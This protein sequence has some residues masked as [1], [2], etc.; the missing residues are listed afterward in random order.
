M[1]L[2]SSVDVKLVKPTSPLNKEIKESGKRF[3]AR[4]KTMP[5][6][7]VTSP[8][9]R[10]AA[11]E[12]NIK[13]DVESVAKAAPKQQ[14]HSPLKKEIK[15]SGKRFFA[16]KAT[17]PLQDIT[18]PSS[19]LAALKSNIKGD[20]E[21][22][23]PK[24]APQQAPTQKPVFVRD[25]FPQPKPMSPR[26][27][28]Q[29]IAVDCGEHPATLPKYDDDND[30]MTYTNT[31]R[32]HSRRGILISCPE[33]VEIQKML[34]ASVIEIE[35]DDSSLSICVN[36]SR[37]KR[38]L[39]RSVSRRRGS[40]ASLRT[41]SNSRRN[42]ASEVAFFEDEFAQALGL[43]NSSNN[44]S[45]EEKSTAYTGYQSPLREI[46][47]NQPTRKSLTSLSLPVQSAQERVSSVSPFGASRNFSIVVE[48]PSFLHHDLLSDGTLAYS[49][50]MVIADESKVIEKKSWGRRMSDKLLKP[51]IR[52]H[53][54]ESGRSASTFSGHAAS[55][56]GSSL[57]YPLT[58]GSTPGSN[59]HQLDAE[60]LASNSKTHEAARDVTSNGVLRSHEQGL[61]SASKNA[62]SRVRT[63]GNQP[64]VAQAQI[65]QPK[66]RVPIVEPF[67][68]A[69]RRHLVQ[70]CDYENPLHQPFDP[71]TSA[72]SQSGMRG[73]DFRL[74]A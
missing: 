5:L 49:K 57:L 35:T 58:D 8:S 2:P 10:L 53:S 66:G 56:T 52:S 50:S 48:E 47:S 19:R 24:A 7:N 63:N 26:S 33:E 60:N 21:N 28:L 18:S 42:V 74:R 59:V 9:S 37:S 71:A 55:R 46:S 40:T 31:T 45:S 43:S 6:Q 30:S 39:T 29:A 62:G 70:Q 34:S 32:T 41:Q 72:W 12:S 20:L 11:L 65:A 14:P 16:R 69:Y 13:G 4:K 73:G 3:F 23:T 64:S 27:R 44:E 25:L 36:Y 17:I 54:N 67:S 68:V 61:P 15:D 38:G 1:S 22:N 51:F